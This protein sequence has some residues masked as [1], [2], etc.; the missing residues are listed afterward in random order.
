M[1]VPIRAASLSAALVMTVV[2]AGCGGDGFGPADG[3]RCTVGTIAP[4]D[5]VSGAVTASSCE[6]F[7]PDS[8]QI[9]YAQS[10]TMLA[11]RNTAYIVRL[12]EGKGLDSLG[13]LY[14]SLEAFAV[15]HQGDP[16]LVTGWWRSYGAPNPNGGQDVEMF[17]TPDEDRTVSLRVFSYTK[18]D[19]GAYSL[20]VERCPIT[21]FDASAAS[22]DG[23]DLRH[24]CHAESIDFANPGSPVKL[25]F[26]SFPTAADVAD[27]VIIDRTGGLGSVWS[28]VGGPGIDVACWGGECTSAG[29][30]FGTS[31]RYRVAPSL[32]GRMTVL[33]GVRGD[34]AATISLRIRTTPPPAPTRAPNVD[35]GDR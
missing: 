25:S 20:V 23:I 28:Y 14:G 35:Q 11:Q 27:S 6:A 13:H 7:D 1:H 24:G 15:N 3:P 31:A 26:F 19:T 21:L 29:D 17:L 10:W 34:S 30:A 12:R 2:L 4:G 33:A 32:P 22:H 18:A 5:S 16:S 9:T 8:R